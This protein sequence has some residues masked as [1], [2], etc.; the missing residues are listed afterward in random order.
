M[1]LPSEAWISQ[2]VGLVCVIVTSP[3]CT[4]A[5]SGPARATAAGPTAIRPVSA[6]ASAVSRKRGSER[7][8]ASGLKRT[9]VAHDGGEMGF[10]IAGLGALDVGQGVA[11]VEA[12]AQVVAH[13]QLHAHAE[14]REVL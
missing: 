7:E 2:S 1:M 11:V 10:G 12:Q 14:R 5:P 6:E 9:S 8:R 4:E 13:Q 3:C